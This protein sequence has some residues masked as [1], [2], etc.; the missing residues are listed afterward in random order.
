MIQAHNSSSSKRNLLADER[1]SPA[2]KTNK[3]DQH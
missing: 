3:K 1:K 2:V